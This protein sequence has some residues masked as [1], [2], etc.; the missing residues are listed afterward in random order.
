MAL[1]GYGH[2]GPNL[3]RSLEGVDGAEL[4]A[5]SVRSDAAAAAVAE[6]R[7]GIFVTTDLDAMLERPEVDVVGVATPA[8]THPALAA[9]ALRADKH[10]LVEKPLAT[11]LRQAEEL[12]ALAAQRGRTLM[13]GYVYFYHPAVRRLGELLCAGKLGELV[14]VIFERANPTA[15][16]SGVLLNSAQPGISKVFF[17]PRT[18]P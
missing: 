13:V 2:W 4:R 10:V 14:C 11:D 7:P 8:P 17:R 18:L 16:P 5:I 15:T 1:V 3:A 6:E 9:R 12:V